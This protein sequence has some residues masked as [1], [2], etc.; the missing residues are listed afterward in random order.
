MWYA[1]QLPIASTYISCY[2]A[3]GGAQQIDAFVVNP[4]TAFFTEYIHTQSDLFEGIYFNAGNASKPTD[5]SWASQQG[6]TYYSRD[7]YTGG[8]KLFD[9]VWLLNDGS[10][11]YYNCSSLDIFEA[12]ENNI[13]PNYEPNSDFE[14]SLCYGGMHSSLKTQFSN[15]KEHLHTVIQFDQ[16]YRQTGEDY[17]F[18]IFLS[19]RIQNTPIAIPLAGDL[20]SIHNTA[21]FPSEA[22]EIAFHGTKMLYTRNTLHQFIRAND[23]TIGSLFAEYDEELSQY[24]L[25]LETGGNTFDSVLI[26]FY[27]YAIRYAFGLHVIQPSVITPGEMFDKTYSYADASPDGRACTEAS[28]P[29]WISVNI[30]SI[31]PGI[32]DNAEY[33]NLGYTYNKDSE[34][35]KI[36]C[37]TTPIER[38]RSVSGMVLGNTITIFKN[39][40]HQYH[41]ITFSS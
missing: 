25:N 16:T 5:T 3:C 24:C 27:P 22:L 1:G 37:T 33:D 35:S 11:T 18:E 20:W 34:S 38:I 6:I 31:V 36:F 17:W 39:S 4:T 9:Q 41:N 32:C 19:S 29:E 2:Q 28:T 15:Q 14:N 26:Q 8:L 40:S 7:V 30:D 23:N 13:I 10:Y 21:G 12:W